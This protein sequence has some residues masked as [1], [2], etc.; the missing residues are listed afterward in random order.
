V[1]DGDGGSVAPAV[2]WLVWVLR[3]VGRA[4]ML[5]CGV[6]AGVVQGGMESRGGTGKGAGPFVGG[7][8]PAGRHGETG[9]GMGGWV[10]RCR[11]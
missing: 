8:T 1:K 5:V 4:V 10:G 6:C 3:G 2:V 9:R 11:P 7:G